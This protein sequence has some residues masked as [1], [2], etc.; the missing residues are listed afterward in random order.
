MAWFVRGPGGM[1]V[2]SLVPKVQKQQG[3]DQ[4][5]GKGGQAKPLS[6]AHGAGPGA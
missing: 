4:L 3:Q 6:G 1:G 2:R 5:A